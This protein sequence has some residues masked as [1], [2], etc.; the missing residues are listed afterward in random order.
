MKIIEELY[1]IYLDHPNVVTDSRLVTPGSVFFGLRGENHNGNRFASRALEN[2][3]AWA[4]IDD[5]EAAAG[6]RILLVD[7]SLLALQ[8]LATRH[9]S[10]LDTT[11]IGIT[12]SN[13]KT[14]T[15]E[16]IGLALSASFP[17]FITPGNLNNHIGVPLTLLSIPPGSR[18][19]VVEMGANHRGEIAALCQI[20]RPDYGLI[21]NIGLAHLEGFGGPEG[22]ALG[23]SELYRFLENN[24]GKIFLHI[25]DEKLVGL[26]RGITAITY[27]NEPDALCRG[28]L[29][30]SEPSLSVEWAF[31]KLSGIIETSLYG[32]YNFENVMAAL[33]IGLYFG[34]E[35]EKLVRSIES[36]IPSNNRSQLILTKTN[37]LRLD[38]YNANPSSMKAALTSFLA[39]AGKDS[40]VILGDMMELGEYSRAEHFEIARWLA[41]SGIE[42]VILIGDTFHEISSQMNLLSFRTLEEAAGFLQTSAITGKQVLIKGSRKMELEKLVKYF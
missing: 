21:T 14:T 42:T 23:K 6:D 13:G 37:T 33:T 11:V 29:I 34:A 26:S 36:Y 40:A 41:R 30:Q 22:V 5:P 17:T 38:A 25:G 35:P 10:S 28:R 20:A 2:G 1:R 24:G 12:G 4:V 8:E 27:G 15:K 7:D 31:G 32:R 18:F 19:A 39:I 3:A 16:L 9:R